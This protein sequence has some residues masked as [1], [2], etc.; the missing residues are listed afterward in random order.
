[1]G[2]VL[3]PFIALCLLVVYISAIVFVIALLWRI[4]SALEKIARLQLEMTRDIK[5]IAQA[6]LRQP[7]EPE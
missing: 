1:M 7:E 6:T 2:N 5:Q 4:A 3:G